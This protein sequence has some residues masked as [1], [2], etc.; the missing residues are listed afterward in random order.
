MKTLTLILTLLAGLLPASARLGWTLEQ[1]EKQ[2]G[3]PVN[4]D[5]TLAALQ[6]Y[7]FYVGNFV[8]VCEFENGV[9]G[10]ITYSKKDGSGFAPVEAS[11]LVHKNAPGVHW[12][13]PVIG[14]NRCTS[15]DVTYNEYFATMYSVSDTTHSEAYSVYIYSGKEA[16][17]CLWFRISVKWAACLKRKWPM[18]SKL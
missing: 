9:V 14:Y 18:S 1:C 12:T 10:A 17:D 3:S 2:Y 16:Q 6:G 13:Q 4:S 5:L 11:D 7:E 8:L 15:G